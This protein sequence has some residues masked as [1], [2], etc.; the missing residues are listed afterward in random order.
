MS[1]ILL[2]TLVGHNTEHHIVGGTHGLLAYAG[3]VAYRAVHIGI[4]DTFY[5]GYMLA[6]ARQQGRQQGCRYPRAYLERATGLGA[7]A[8]H[9]RQVGYHVLHSMTQVGIAAKIGRAHV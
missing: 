1:I 3:Q 6:L 9:A 2:H 7:V 5:L 4:D 8:Y